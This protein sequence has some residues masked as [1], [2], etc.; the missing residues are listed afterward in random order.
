VLIGAGA[1][2]CAGVRVA[3]PSV[4]GPLTIVGANTTIES[5]VVWEE[6]RIGEHARI[7]RTV[8]GAYVG[9]GDR[10][11]VEDAILGNAAEVEEDHQPEPGARIMPGDRV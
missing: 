3:G 2:L 1:K 4:I 11:V 9:I 7:V 6:C 5:S 10:A 8:L